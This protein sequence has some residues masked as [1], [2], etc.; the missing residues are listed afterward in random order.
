[1]L[2]EFIKQL[3]HHDWFYSY[4]DDHNVWK[5]GKEENARLSAIADSG[6]PFKMAYD[7]V[8]EY[9]M[10]DHSL[11]DFAKLDNKLKEAKALEK[12]ND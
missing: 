3:M 7:A 4:S 10:Q 1:M 6:K 12:H 2:E 11:R 9:M 8:S 5:A